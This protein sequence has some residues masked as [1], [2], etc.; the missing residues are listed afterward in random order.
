MI[1]SP[2]SSRGLDHQPRRDHGSGRICGR[3]WTCWTSVG[4][5][6]LA[7][8]GVRCQSIGECQGRK[9]GVVGGW[10]STLIEAGSEGE[11]MG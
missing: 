4:G 3:G 1:D 11:K 6:A 7:P 5:A 2:W 10:V 9:P 8:E